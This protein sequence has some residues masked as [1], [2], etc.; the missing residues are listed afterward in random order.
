MSYFYNS[1]VAATIIFVTTADDALWLVP[2]VASSSLTTRSKI[3]NAIAFILTI[4]IVVL[5]DVLLVKSFGA[6][7][8]DR[9]RGGEEHLPAIAA[10]VAWLI[11]GYL[12]IKKVLK[13]RRATY[14]N[15]G[16]ESPL[17][18]PNPVDISQPE[19]TE[20]Q[21]LLV[22]SLAFLGALD[23]LAYFPTLLIGKTFTGFEL[24]MGAFLACC[25]I[26]IVITM[27]LARFRPTLE[28]LDSI[29]LYVI[30][31]IFAMFLTL[32]ALAS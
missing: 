10:F 27:V 21:P 3:T 14:Q 6:L 5:I 2:F 7:I 28:Y 18:S 30:V 24:S 23:E 11:A 26:L 22:C 17:V 16:E 25:F 31:G 4:Q 13:N 15:L 19:P 12:Y 8:I 29:P 1:I 32:E 9:M 20:S